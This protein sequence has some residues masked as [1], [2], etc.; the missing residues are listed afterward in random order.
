[1]LAWV[2]NGIF[3]SACVITDT[4]ILLNIILYWAGVRHVSQLLTR[5]VSRGK[6]ERWPHAFCCF[7][8]HQSNFPS[9]PYSH[10]RFLSFLLSLFNPVT[11]SSPF[12]VTLLLHPLVPPSH[13]IVSP[14]AKPSYIYA[15]WS[16]LSCIT[17]SQMR[18]SC[19]MTTNRTHTALSHVA[20]SYRFVSHQG[21]LL[22]P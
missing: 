1:M 17:C 19:P 11:S 4:D 3:I 5:A 7:H 13:S 20:Q 9:P 8:R 15:E 2:W 18:P 21:T 10:P 12:L 14:L 16:L 22:T 6:I